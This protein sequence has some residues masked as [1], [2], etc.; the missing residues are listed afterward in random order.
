MT[1]CKENKLNNF[2]LVNAVF[3]HEINIGK[4]PSVALKFVILTFFECITPYLIMQVVLSAS[5]AGP[6]QQ[7]YR[8][9]AKQCSEASSYATTHMNK[10]VHGL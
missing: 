7:H 4:V 2:F 9:R 8:L 3:C 10:N 1:F 5:A 6:S